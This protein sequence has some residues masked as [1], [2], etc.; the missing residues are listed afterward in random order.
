ME[1][2]VKIDQTFDT[3]KVILQLDFGFAELKVQKIINVHA[4]LRDIFL[5][6]EIIAL[7]YQSNQF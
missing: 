5:K 7:V 1:P 2:F 3:L 6:R 4:R